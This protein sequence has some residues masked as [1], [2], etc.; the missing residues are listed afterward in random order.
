[1]AGADP[2]VTMSWGYDMLVDARRTQ[3]LEAD[4]RF[5]IQRSSMMVVD[6]DA[7]KKAVSGFGFDVPRV[8]QFPWGVDLNHFQPEPLRICRKQFGWPEERFVVLSLRAWEPIYDV[9][10]IVEGF[11][12][13][14]RVDPSLY[15]VLLGGGSQR[16]QL[17]Q[18]LTE[19]GVMETVLF[20]GRIAYQQLPCYYQA[21]DLYAS[22]SLT[23]GSSVSLLEAF[24]CGTPALVSDIPGNRE[25]LDEG[26]EGWFF[27]VGDADMVAEKILLAAGNRSQ[28]PNMGHLARKRVERYANWKEN[29]PK[30][31]QA[32][33]MAIQYQRSL[34]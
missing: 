24:A 15:L 16:D 13:A 28:L 11:I 5:V 25:W 26:G 34:P 12:Q 18:R 21:A 14:V 10:T 31:I 17:Q 19:A 22:A 2:L 1:M 3:A 27:P 23:D 29:F 6:C 20:G 9:A 4:T 8:V 7:V 32:Y 33:E 30:L